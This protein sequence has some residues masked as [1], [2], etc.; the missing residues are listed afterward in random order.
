MN[1][2]VYFVALAFFALLLLLPSVFLLIT[3]AITL[4][5][6]TIVLGW[7]IW[8]QRG[9]VDET[10]RAKLKSDP[11]W[12][13]TRRRSQSAS[14]SDQTITII[15]IGFTWS[16]FVYLGTPSV[17]LLG[18]GL[19]FPSPGL[20]AVPPAELVGLLLSIAG[21]VLL[22]AALWWMYAVGLAESRVDNY[23]P[24]VIEPVPP[25][26][27]VFCEFSAA[28]RYAI[29]N[30]EPPNS[31]HADR[32]SGTMMY[33]TLLALDGSLPRRFAICQPHRTVLVRVEAWGRRIVAR[34]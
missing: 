33:C 12:A 5:A 28:Y 20:S 21:L 26:D 30:A 11:L 22:T 25:E 23:R 32:H 9:A 3:L 13:E 16:L 4:L 24:E 2:S 31:D 8:R 6:M 18:P 19:T 27:S 1:V 7:Q 29:A 14:F 15:F 10:T 34:R 17:Q